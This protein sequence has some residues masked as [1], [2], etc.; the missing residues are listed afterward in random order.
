MGGPRLTIYCAFSA[1][2]LAVGS[3]KG[4]CWL[5]FLLLAGCCW[6]GKGVQSSG[7]RMGRVL[8][9]F[10]DLMIDYWFSLMSFSQVAKT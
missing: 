9:G 5:G 8:R 6:R 10:D 3:S 1:R 2:M 7:K 4:C